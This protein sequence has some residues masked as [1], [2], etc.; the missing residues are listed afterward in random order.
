VDDQDGGTQTTPAGLMRLASVVAG[1]VREGVLDTRFGGKLQRRLD[2]EA[3]R[4]IEYGPSALGEAGKD[5]LFAAIGE[6][7]L[8]LRQR[9]AA[10]LVEANAR[11]RA[12]EE[13]RPDKRRKKKD[14][15]A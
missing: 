15:E 1:M 14:E 12:S 5:D 3:R 13:E 6:L 4:I 7:D 10:L 2:K 11:L 8:A 9:D